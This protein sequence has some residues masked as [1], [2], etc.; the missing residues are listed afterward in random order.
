MKENRQNFEKQD[1]FY[2][3]ETVASATECTGLTPSAVLDDQE[4][5]AYAELYAIHRQPPV[6]YVDHE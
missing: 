2:N 1:P 6:E 4:G 5:E 3:L